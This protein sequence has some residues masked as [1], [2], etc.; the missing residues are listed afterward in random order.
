V[1]TRDPEK[2]NVYQAIKASNCGLASRINQRTHKEEFAR[3]TA[4]GIRIIKGHTDCTVV[5]QI[6]AEQELAREWHAVNADSE[7][8]KLGTHRLSSDQPHVDAA[9]EGCPNED[10]EEM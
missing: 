10:P 2:L 4:S 5:R 8:L 9:T 7:S 3:N 1:I 6:S